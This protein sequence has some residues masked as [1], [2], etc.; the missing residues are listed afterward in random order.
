M[1]V[2]I[3]TDVSVHFP[4]TFINFDGRFSARTPG[5][6]YK[7]WK[8]NKNNKH[9][10]TRI[11]IHPRKHYNTSTNGQVYTITDK[12]LTEQGADPIK[13]KQI[14]YIKGLAKTIKRL[15]RSRPE[16]NQDQ[17]EIQR[18][19]TSIE[20]LP[21]RKLLELRYQHMADNHITRHPEKR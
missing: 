1:K 8:D 6:N 21:S 16:E 12:G 10:K 2:K 20:K 13:R 15:S 9:N 4:P 17:K 7:Q 19:W 11:R 18:E 3:G 5:M 14:S